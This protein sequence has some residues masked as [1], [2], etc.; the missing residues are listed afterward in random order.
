MTNIRWLISDGL[1]LNEG[2]VG[3]LHD[4]LEIMENIEKREMNLLQMFMR[5]HQSPCRFY[6][7]QLRRILTVMVWPPRQL[8]VV[9]AIG[10]AGFPAAI[11]S[12]PV[13]MPW[14]ARIRN[15]P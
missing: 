14:A 8:S 10:G 5:R 11:T 6:T 4:I 3:F 1:C 2:E 13:P 12:S 15:N 9:P 7:N